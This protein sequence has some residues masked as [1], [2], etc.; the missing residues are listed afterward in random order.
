LDK[1]LGALKSQLA[2]K[3]DNGRKMIAS[4]PAP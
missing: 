3:K 2:R 1:W 4:H